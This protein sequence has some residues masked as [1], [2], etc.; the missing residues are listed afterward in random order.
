VTLAAHVIVED[1]TL[2]GIRATRA[3]YEDGK[4]RALDR[5]HGPKTDQIFRAWADTW[6]R[7]RDP[8]FASLI[9]H[10]TVRVRKL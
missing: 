5:Y 9:Q 2:A 4:L 1:V 3:A 6:L 8:G 10:S 7:S